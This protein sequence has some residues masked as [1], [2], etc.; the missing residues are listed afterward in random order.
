MHFISKLDT[1]IVWTRYKGCLA[2]NPRNKS[3]KARYIYNLEINP[4]SRRRNGRERRSHFSEKV[5]NKIEFMTFL[6]MRFGNDYH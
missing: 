1:K 4:P 6:N 3:F 5:S 2:K